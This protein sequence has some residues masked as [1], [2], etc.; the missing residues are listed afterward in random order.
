[1]G[2]KISDNFDTVQNF[3]NPGDICAKLR[4]PHANTSAS[5]V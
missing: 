5:I 2:A 4:P 1:M 3:P